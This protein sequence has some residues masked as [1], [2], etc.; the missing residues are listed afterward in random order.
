M[1]GEIH[2]TDFFVEKV[3]AKKEKEEITQMFKKVLAVTLA[4]TMALTMV[5]CSSK[6]KVGDGEVKLGDYK[7]LVVYADDVACS[8]A[9]YETVKESFLQQCTTT[10]LKKSGKVKKD[11][12]VNVDYE[13]KIEVDGKMVAF[14]GGTS[15]SAVDIDM[16]NDAGNYIEGF[17]DALKGHKAGDKFT[18]HLKFPDDYSGTTVV[19]EEEIK[20]AGKDVDFTFTIHGLQVSTTPEFTDELVK[21]NSGMDDVTTKAE[22]EEYV[23]SS[24]RSNNIINKVWSKFVEECEV[25]TYD[26]TVM[27]EVNDYFETYLSSSYGTTLDKYLEASGMTEDQWKEEVIR[28]EVKNRMIINAIAKKEG[29][30]LSDD[31]YKKEAESMA[32]QYGVDLETYE[33]NYGGKDY[34]EL[35]LT[36]QRVQEFVVDNVEEKEGSEPTTKAPE[37]TTEET[38][39]EK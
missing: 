7:G 3:F 29:L 5:G 10:E 12:V 24:T 32:A 16:A 38:T 21:E 34:V 25:I 28:P 9:D 30:T 23:R 13:G 20:L 31:E 8:D 19:N 22:F 39:T 15:T 36:A 27:E 18:A 14:D 6:V 26:E 2:T 1:C 33:S 11:S 17:V 37:T 35:T 4:A